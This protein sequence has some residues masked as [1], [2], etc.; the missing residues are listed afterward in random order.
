MQA[1]A[2]HRVIAYS[3]VST[4]EQAD[5]GAGL[6]AQRSAIES[7]CQDRGWELVDLV[8]DRGYSAKALKRPGIQRVLTRMKAGEADALLVARLDRL[9]RSLMDFAGLM[10]RA[11]REGYGLV[12][13]D[14]GVDT[15]TPSGELIA[16][17]LASF[18]QYERRLIGQRTK[19]G[20][21]EHKAQGKHMGRRSTLPVRVRK[22]IERERGRGLTLKAIADGLNADGV[23]TGQGGSEWRP[24]SVR[25]VTRSA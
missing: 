4:T 20:M 25:A 1:Q 10:S 22:R 7:A 8:E 14:L 15:S 9:S 23:P 6:D 2:I 16:N 3:R 19:E 13:L 17:V 5:D 11:Q 24:S 18:S 12:A 21:A